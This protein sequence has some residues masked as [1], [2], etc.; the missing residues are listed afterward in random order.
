MDTPFPY[1]KF[2]TGR[3]FIGRSAETKALANL[4]AQGE[5]IV[6]YEPPKTGKMSLVQQTF[7][8]MK[9]SGRLF[10]GVLFSL[11]SVRTIQDLALD[12][13]SAALRSAGAD[14]ALYEELACSLLAGT[15][16]VFD[17][18]RYETF[19]E[20]LSPAGPLDMEDLRAAFLL[21]YRIALRT[22]QKRFVVIT[23]FQNVMLTE[24][25]DGVCRLLEDVFRTLPD[26]L[27][28]WAS[29]VFVGSQVNAMHEIFGV[30]RWFWRR[31]ERIRLDPIDAKDITE[32][33][34]RGFLTT[35]KVI[36][37]EL[38]KGVIRL[39]CG[40]IWYI[41]HFGAICDSLS[42]GYIM[43]Q[44]LRD[45]L[46]RLTAIHE[47]RFVATM[48]DLTTFQ[49]SLL[50]AILDGRQRFS[51]AD[52]IRQYGLNSSANVRRLKDALCKKEI[53]T[54]DEDENATLLDPLFE[55]WVR[56]FYF[57]MNNA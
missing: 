34:I 9:S 30:K 36:D 55:Y 24:D 21:P 49:V 51:S 5:H 40:N 54:F 13:A 1:E 12:L 53:V 20:I 23:E 57:K 38:L 39:F 25:G 42:R 52:V 27:G 50:R 56:K 48:N 3:Q 10:E 18:E 17:K 31:V 14:P 46:A 47:P 41:N 7:F 45:A 11:L 26:E 2:V 32:H 44:T 6:I 28:G 16:M 4:L 35:G 8:N 43:E 33:V 29:Y 37:R 15:R 22:G 19:G